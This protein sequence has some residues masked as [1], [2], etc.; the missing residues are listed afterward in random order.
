MPLRVDLNFEIRRRWPPVITRARARRLIRRALRTTLRMEGI[1][2]ASLEVTLLDDAGISAL[3]QRYFSDGSPTD[4][5][6]FTLYG[7][8]EDPAG[9]IYIG[10]DQALRQAAAHGEKP[11][12]E[13]VRLVIHGMLHLLGYDHPE[14]TDREQSEMWIRQ[15]EIFRK[16]IGI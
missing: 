1:S 2:D 7:D 10:W 14:G 8:G 3:N 6:A 13:L 9:E 12:A 11:A 5:I 16:V 15:E 4:V